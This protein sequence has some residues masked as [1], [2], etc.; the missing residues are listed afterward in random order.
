[1]RTGNC[2]RCG[3]CCRGHKLSKGLTAIE[4]FILR[5]IVPEEEINRLKEDGTCPFLKDLP[6]GTTECTNY[7]NRPDFCRIYPATPEDIRNIDRCGFKFVD[8]N[9]QDKD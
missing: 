3:D 1:M 6:D 4:W 7:D 8:N 5:R 2:N 9:E